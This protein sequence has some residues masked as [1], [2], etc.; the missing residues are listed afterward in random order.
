[1]AR[2]WPVRPR[3]GTVER[4]CARLRPRG[5]DLLNPMRRLLVA[6]ICALALTG[7]TVRIGG[8]QPLNVVLFVIDDVRW[9][10]IGAAGNKVVHTPRLDRLASEG[11]LFRQ[12]RVTTSICM[13]SR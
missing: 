9:D 3:P 11:V 6:S 8:E 4:H 2:R 1:M 10:S 13:V 5:A 7:D 12:A